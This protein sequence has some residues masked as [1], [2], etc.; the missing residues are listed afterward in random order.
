MTQET[1]IKLFEAKQVR[2]VWDAAKG[3]WY[4][5]IIDVVAILTASTDHGAYWR[6]LKERLKKEGNETV[7]NCH[8]LKMTAGCIKM[9]WRRT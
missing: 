7:T 8:G 3:R 4:F 6:K 9:F 1:A 2:S 5:A